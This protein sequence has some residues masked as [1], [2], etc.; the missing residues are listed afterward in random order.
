MADAAMGGGIFNVLINLS[1][2][3]DKHF[4]EKM[5]KELQRLEG[6]GEAIKKAILTRIK[7]KINRP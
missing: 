1:A 7:K 3:E 6:E 2:L 5:K 4:V